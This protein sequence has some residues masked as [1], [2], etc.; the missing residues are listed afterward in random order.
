MVD[1]FSH[2]L[3]IIPVHLRAHWCLAAIDFQNKSVEYYDSKGS[4][5]NKCQQSLM[6]YLQDESLDT[7]MSKLDT[8]GWQ[9]ENVQKIP[10][11]MNEND[12]GVFTCTFAEYICHSA[13][14]S[15]TQEEIPYFQRKMV[16]EIYPCKLLI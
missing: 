10:Q 2:Y 4:P 5:N 9:T 16:Y 6:K 14:I 13:D 11:H 8:S 12:C 7:K 3:I 1:I 15:V